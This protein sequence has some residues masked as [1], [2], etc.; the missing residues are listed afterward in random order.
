VT[1]KPTAAPKFSNAKDLTLSAITVDQAGSLFMLVQ[2][3]WGQ[4]DRGEESR[5]Q[6]ILSFD[7]KGKYNSYLEVDWRDI[8]VQQFVALGSGGFLLRGHRTNTSEERIGILS[9]DGSVLQDIARFP[10][11]MIEELSLERSPQPDHMARG[12]DGRVY[13]VD[14]NSN[15]RKDLVYAFSSDGAFEEAFSLARLPRQLQLIG[16]NAAGN[17]LAAT[18]GEPDPSDLLR[19]RWWIAVYSNVASHGELQAVY[20]PAPSPPLCYRHELVDRF[21][22]LGDGGRLVTM[23]P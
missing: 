19:R 1:I 20:G 8:S 22:F 2:A 13:F 21:T 17:R 10:T 23:S 11:K 16:W 3:T 4:R 18:Y 14:Q 15:Q 9:S 12:G 7:K 5:G 6:Y